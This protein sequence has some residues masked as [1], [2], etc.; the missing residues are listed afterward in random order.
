MIESFLF[1]ALPYVALF[2]CIFGS[3]YRIRTQ[4]ISYSS[5]SSQFLESQGLM[6]G[7]LPWHIGILLILLG[8]FIALLLPG[9]WHS[10]MLHSLVLASVEASGLGLSILC[11]IGLIVL[12]VRRISSAKIQSVTTPMDLVVL[13]LLLG[14]VTLGMVTATM[15][16]WGALWCSATTTPYVWSI[17]TFRPD[18]SFV[19][20]LPI[21]M[22]M[23]IIGAWLLILLIP[24]SRLIHMFAVPIQYLFRPPQIVEWTSERKEEAAGEIFESEETRRHFMHATIG[25]GSGLALLSIGIM[26]KLLRFFLG[27][28]LSQKEESELMEFKL[29]QLERTAH[30]K[31]L[32]LERQENPYILIGTL[33]ELNPTTGKYFIDY[34]MTPAMAFKGDDGLPN[35]LSA[36]CTHLGCTVANQVNSDGKVVCPCHLSY[37]NI[38]TGQPDQD[39]PAKAPLPHLGWVLMDT[40]G[41]VLASRTAQGEFTGSIDPT[42]LQ[43]ARVYIAKKLSE[44]TT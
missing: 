7:S 35:L 22:R 6:W 44:G 28:R 19:Q 38:K 18:I 40:K 8:H 1:G 17:L 36:K 2:V 10:L 24:F 9:L 4:P 27:P 15:H 37:F 21:A 43:G 34:K 42:K 11:V 5:L 39:A 41:N 32:E 25:I 12:A 29:K 13:F 33:E 26:D 31:S 20:D 30:Q 16:K 23:H 3:I 14:Q